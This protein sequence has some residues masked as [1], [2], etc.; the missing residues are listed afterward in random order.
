MQQVGLNEGLNRQVAWQRQ[1]LPPPNM[2]DTGNDP[3]AL[4]SA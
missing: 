4:A 2:S 1:V 3:E